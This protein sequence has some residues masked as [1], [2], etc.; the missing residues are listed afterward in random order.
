[1][2]Q[3]QMQ[4]LAQRNNRGKLVACEALPQGSAAT[5]LPVFFE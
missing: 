1:M 5:P 4:L 3:W 2:A